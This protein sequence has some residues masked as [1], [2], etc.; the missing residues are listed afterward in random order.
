MTV[1]KKQFKAALIKYR[2]TDM[3]SPVWFWIN[4]SSGASLSPSF[5]TQEKAEAWFESIVTI[6]TET[7]DFLDRIKNGRFYIV[8]GRVDVGD[9]ISSKKGNECPFTMHLDDD[10]LSVEVLATSYRDAKNRVEEY[11]EILEWINE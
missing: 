10:I 11:F 6:H 5:S 8:K 3:E 2:Q 1:Q 7:Y 9:V 4:P